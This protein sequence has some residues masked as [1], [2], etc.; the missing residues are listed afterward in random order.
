MQGVELCT[1]PFPKLSYLIN[2]IFCGCPRCLEN[3]INMSDE[4]GQFLCCKGMKA[5][6]TDWL[7]RM[8]ADD[9]I[10]YMVKFVCVPIWCL[11]KKCSELMIFGKST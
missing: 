2:Y 4:L 6:L 8:K 7:N 5:N 9:Q 3:T 1:A 10:Y 11:F